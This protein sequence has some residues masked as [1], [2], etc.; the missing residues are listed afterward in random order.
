MEMFD[1]FFFF[2]VFS[3]GWEQDTGEIIQEK[4][5][6][7]EFFF[8]KKRKKQ[9]SGEFQLNICCDGCNFPLAYNRCCNLCFQKV[10][11]QGYFPDVVEFILSLHAS[12]WAWEGGKGGGQHCDSGLAWTTGL[13]ADS[14]SEEW[15]LAF[16]F[17]LSVLKWPWEIQSCYFLQAWTGLIFGTPQIQ[18][19]VCLF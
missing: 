19:F 5:N 10:G 3:L 6:L 7:R 16:F 12:K 4:T 8:I 17:L 13:F 9:C 14:Q 2:N 11:K 18:F 15:L 1:F